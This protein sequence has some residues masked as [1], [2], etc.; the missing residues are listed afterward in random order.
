MNKFLLSVV[1]AGTAAVMI[2]CGGGVSQLTKERVARS[3]TAVQQ[4]T[5][6]LGNSEAGAVELQ[7]AKDTLQQARRAVDQE[8]DKLANQM[9]QQAQLDAELALAKADTASARKAADEVLASIE[10]LRNEA[11]RG[12]P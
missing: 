2:G 5:Q 7:R 8:N 4:A 10:T 6:A 9:A 12:N 3:E 11:A 1:G